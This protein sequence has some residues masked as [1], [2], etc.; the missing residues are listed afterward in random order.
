MIWVTKTCTRMFA[1]RSYDGSTAWSLKEQ[2]I[3]EF[4]IDLSTTGRSFDFFLFHPHLGWWDTWTIIDCR[5]C[6]DIHALIFT[7]STFLLVSFL[8]WI[9]ALLFWFDF[10]DFML[11]WQKNVHVCVL[12][13][14]YSTLVFPGITL[15]SQEDTLRSIIF[16]LSEP[17]Y[18][19]VLGHRNTQLYTYDMWYFLIAIYKLLLW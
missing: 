13:G 12:V 8:S 7:N 14:G 4:R 19:F 15:I 18:F 5:F 16:P 11:T 2:H 17:Y 9:D 3:P 10:F 6:V 1:G